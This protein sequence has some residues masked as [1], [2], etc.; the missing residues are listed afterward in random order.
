MKLGTNTQAR[1]YPRDFI[2]LQPSSSTDHHMKNHPLLR[3]F[4]LALPAFAA[5]TAAVL[6][7]APARAGGSQAQL[8][9]DGKVAVYGIYTGTS[10]LAFRFANDATGKALVLTST[11]G[12]SL[13]SLGGDSIYAYALSTDGST[14]VGQGNLAGNSTSHAF[15][16]KGGV[17][18]DLGT[19]GTGTS[20]AA[21]LVSADGSVAA[22][23]AT[24]LGG[25][26]PHAFRWTAGGGMVDLGVL[27]TGTE[28]YV[29]AMT[30]DGSVIVGQ[31]SITG[32]SYRAFR[33]AGGTMTNLGVLGTGTYSY[34]RF[35]STDGS[36]VVG[37]SATAG[38]NNEHA[39]RWTGGIMT[40]LGVLGSGD[41]SGAQAMTPDGSVIV[42]Y[43]TTGS[44]MIGLVAPGGGGAAAI[45][46]S[47]TRAFRWSG[48]TMSDLG[49]LGGTNARAELVSAD[50]GV[51]VGYSQ[52]T[53]N[54]LAQSF[55]WTTGSGMVNMNTRTD[56]F[57]ASSSYPMAMNSTGTV[58]VGGLGDGRF[59]SLTAPGSG[60]PSESA[61]PTSAAF[62]WTPTAGMQT[63]EEWLTAAGVTVAP[64]FRTGVAT[65]VSEDGAVVV[66]QTSD[67]QPFIARG[68]GL[69]TLAQLQEAMATAGSTLNFGADAGWTILN[70]AHGHPLSRR[71]EP[72]HWTA[73]AAGDLGRDDHAARDGQITVGEVGVG[74][75]FGT[76]QANLAVG[77]TIGKQHTPVSG[78]TDLDG[79][80]VITDLITHVPNSSVYVT[81][82]GFYQ[83]SD[84][85]VRRGYLNAGTPDASFSAF[86]AK[87][88]GGSLRADWEN[89]A[90]VAGTGLS[91]YVKFTAVWTDTPTF[92]E[93][94]GGFPATVSA[95]NASTTEITVG[96][97]SSTALARGWHLVGTLEGAHRFQERS[98]TTTADFGPGIGSVTTTGQ[99]FEQDFLRASVGVEVPV[100]KG[101]FTFTVNGTTSAPAASLWLATSY[102]IHF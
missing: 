39:F 84:L 38:S 98:P 67:N 77:K 13:G 21:V 51:V 94:G 28:S 95:L 8:S 93:T 88:Y 23:Y 47:V 83:W 78:Q 10:S 15:R 5:L 91:P 101:V 56:A 53:G 1:V 96:V 58:V 62:R 66:G 54:T 30:P 24:T 59:R 86:Q 36:V 80:F 63:V 6:L 74:H 61:S 72:G 57:A 60:G 65:G 90:T 20:S 69:V 34:A 45:D 46:V 79:I 100:G 68:S 31:S 87:S 42:G 73:W 97:N 26:N 89:A 32:G 41:S 2:Q 40:D 85:D 50:G 70:G 17:I 7:P 76:L 48:G 44:G 33:W 35:V 3:R 92:T 49:T 18:T 82:L 9:K 64:T 27:S 29:Q 52:V 19:L 55:R 25:N 81:L 43:S 22:G 102:Q 75:S 71:A 12:A 37:Q 11:L 14:V 4:R 99:A 16:S